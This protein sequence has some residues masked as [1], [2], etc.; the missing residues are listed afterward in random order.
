MEAATMGKGNDICV[1]D[2]QAVKIV[3]LATNMIEL[4][5]YHT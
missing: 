3:D 5:G 4:A 2:G 1:R